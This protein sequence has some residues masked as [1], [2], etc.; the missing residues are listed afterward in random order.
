MNRRVVIIA[1]VA[2][3][4]GLVACLVLLGLN[5]SIF[6][7]KKFEVS[8]IGLIARAHILTVHFFR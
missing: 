4:L 6:D 8:N 5:Y 1:I 7:P 2:A 3:V